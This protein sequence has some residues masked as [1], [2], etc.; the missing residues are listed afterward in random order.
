MC[1]GL[2]DEY[3]PRKI[4][5]T[6]TLEDSALSCDVVP[7]TFVENFDLNTTVADYSVVRSHGLV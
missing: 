7:A 3:Q 4:E 5:A 6:W 1:T 2:G